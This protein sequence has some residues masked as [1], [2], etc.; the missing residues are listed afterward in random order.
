MLVTYKI[1]FIG[2]MNG[3]RRV[4]QGGNNNNNNNPTQVTASSPNRSTA[5]MSPKPF[6]D[7]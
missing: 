3:I 6:A 4:V 5:P 7:R 2:L 1:L